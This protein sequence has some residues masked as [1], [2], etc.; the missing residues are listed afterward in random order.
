MPAASQPE[1]QD[2]I[3]AAALAALTDAD[4]PPGED[5]WALPDPD[6]GR[7]ATLAG[8]TAAELEQLLAAVPAAV[9]EVIP[10]GCLPRDGTGRGTGFADGGPLDVLVPG[11]ALAGFA[12]DAHARLGAVSDD[13]LIGVLRGWW[14]QTSWAQARALA[15]MAELA[16]RRPADRTPPAPPGQFPARLSEFIPDEI[17]MALTLTKTAAETQLGLALQLTARPATFAALEG[18]RIDLRKALVILDAVALLSAGHAAAVESAVLPAAAG[19]TTGELRR[20]VTAAVLALDP[21][22]LRRRREQAEKGARVECYPDPAGTATLTGRSLPPAEVLAADKRL[23]QVAKYWKKLIRAAWKQADPGG[24]LPRPEHGLDLLRAKA[25]LALLLGQPLEVPPAD[26]LPPAPQAPGPQS[27]A[28][29]A[30]PGEPGPGEPRRDELPAGLRRPDPVAGL[31]P[32]PGLISLTLPLTTFLG[33]SDRPGE[34]AG[35]GPL[36]ADT[37]RLI[38]CALAGHRATRWQIILTDRDGHALAV[39]AARGNPGARSGGGGWTVQVTAEPIATG[40]CDHRNQEAGHD[41][42]PG[43]QRLVRARTGTCTSPGCRRPATSC[44]LDHVCHERR[45][46]LEVASS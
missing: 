4:I 2:D 7:P 35:Y 39:G 22:A 40:H 28:G 26:L 37:V 23:C 13:E 33:V 27:P 34:A 36:H 9:P 41:P 24:Q 44:D 21:D 15:A 5:G 29:S 25:Y 19:Q 30:G 32:M 10:A 8:L 14:R 18:G 31:P 20:S 43:L 42:S 6:T 16:R 45:R 1:S 17:G 3:L 38:A 46:Q 12:D 11:V